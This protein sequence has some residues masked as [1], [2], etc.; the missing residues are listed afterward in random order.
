TPGTNGP[1]PSA[2]YT[3]NGTLIPGSGI[4]GKYAMSPVFSHDGTKLAFYDRSPNQ[5]NGHW[6]GG[7]SMYNYDPVAQK[8]SNYTVLAVPPPT[9]HYA[10][11]A[12]TPDNKYVF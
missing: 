1:W 4:E 3:K 7:L 5:V 11:P 10:W 12:F 8:F 9:H 6:P 2:L